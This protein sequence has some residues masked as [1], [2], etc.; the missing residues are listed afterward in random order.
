MTRERILITV[1]TYP[2]LSESY[3]ELVCTAGVRED[4]RWQED[5]R[6]V[7]KLPWKFS[8]R[9]EDDKGKESTLQILDWETGMLYWKC[10]Q[11]AEEEIALAKVRQKY[12]DQFSKT[13]LHFFMGTTLEHHQKKAPNPWQ[14]IRVF[15]IPHHKQL[16]LI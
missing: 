13:D 5:F 16:G 2:T 9:F 14:I 1:K 12:V 15:P 3:G 8:Y 6:L 4:G 7:P 10:L 11:S